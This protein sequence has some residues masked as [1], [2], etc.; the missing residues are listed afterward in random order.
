MSIFDMKLKIVLLSE[1]FF[2]I[3]TLIS[4][5]FVNCSHVVLESFSVSKCFSC[6]IEKNKGL[7]HEAY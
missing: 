6:K 7:N 2:T 3:V 4:N 5:P 1:A